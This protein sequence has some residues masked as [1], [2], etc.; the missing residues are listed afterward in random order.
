MEEQIATLMKLVRKQ[1]GALTD[2]EDEDPEAPLLEN[3]KVPQIELY[4]GHTNPKPHPAKYNKM[5]QISGRDR[6]PNQ[7][8]PGRNYGLPSGNN[9]LVPITMT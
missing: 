6:L 9:S 8:T 7:S 5:M 1:S 4:D 2:L 3:F